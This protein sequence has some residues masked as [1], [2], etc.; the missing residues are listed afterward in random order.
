MLPGM[1]TRSSELLIKIHLIRYLIALVLVIA[2]LFRAGVTPFSALF[3][4]L[5]AIGILTLAIWK[6]RE[7]A[8]SRFE[9]ILLLALPATVL[10][11]L[12]PLPVAW[13]DALPGRALYARVDIQLPLDLADTWQPLTINTNSTLGA[14]LTLLVPI[15]VYVGCRRLESV[16]L[17]WIAH[18]LLAVAAAEAVLGLIQFGMGKAGHMFLVVSGGHTNSAIGTYANRNHLAGLL[19][20]VLPLCLALLFASLRREPSAIQRLDWYRRAEFL[21]SRHGSKAILYFG[22]SLLLLLGIVFTRS[23]MG[24]MLAIVGLVLTT[25]LMARKL[26]GRTAFGFSGTF[27]VLTLGLGIAIGMAPVLERFSLDVGADGRVPIFSATLKGIEQYLPLGT[28]PGTFTDAI[29]QFQPIEMGHKYINRAHND[30]LEWTSDA[31][32]IAPLLIALAF[33]LYLIQWRCIYGYGARSR[34]NF[35]RVGAGI[36]LLLVAL[37]ELV[38]YNLYIPA[39]QV[40]FSLLAAFFFMPQSQVGYASTSRSPHHHRCTTELGTVTGSISEMPVD[41]PDQSENPFKDC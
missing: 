24:I 16:D 2:P 10:F 6:P 41:C 4:Q 28:G 8:L 14:G 15:A 29:R 37:H 36:G 26:G 33:F 11:Y 40:V 21:G 34:Y 12:I 3:L 13:I 18:L 35:L 23:R 9:I 22:L 5:L 38:D 17:L 1:Q 25:L 31:G 19:Y 20:A 30:Y 27:I 39:N 7:I 32:L